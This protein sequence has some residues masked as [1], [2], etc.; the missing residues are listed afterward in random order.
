MKGMKGVGLGSAVGKHGHTG[1]KAAAIPKVILVVVAAMWEIL[2][3]QSVGMFSL[4]YCDTQRPLAMISPSQ[5]VMGGFVISLHA[6]PSE[7]IS[8]KNCYI[9]FQKFKQET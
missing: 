2:R 7:R 6:M 4:W 5:T 1:Y 8:A 3:V 9:L